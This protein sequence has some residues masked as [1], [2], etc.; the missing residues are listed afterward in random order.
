MGRRG[1]PE[2]RARLTPFLLSKLAGAVQSGLPP[3]PWE[4]WAAGPA[5]VGVQGGIAWDLG[6]AR[7]W[8]CLQPGLAWE[9]VSFPV[10]IRPPTP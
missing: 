1:G 3:G 2:S 9:A 6:G 7:G 8:V 10:G 5:V 4:R